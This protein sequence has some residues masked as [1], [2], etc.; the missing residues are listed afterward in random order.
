[1]PFIISLACI[2]YNMSVLD[3]FKAATYISARSLMLDDKIGSIEKGK[4]ADIIIWNVNNISEIPYR[5]D[6]HPIQKVLK[7]GKPVITA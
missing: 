2:Y 4:N 6:S 5:V 3:A 1:M 7:N